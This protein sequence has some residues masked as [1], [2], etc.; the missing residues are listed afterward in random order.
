[1]VDALL[2]IISYAASPFLLEG[3][4]LAIQIT[5]VATVGGLALGLVLAAMRV[6]SIPPLRWFAWFYIWFVRGTPILLQLIF[7]FD[8]LPMFGVR[9]DN[10]TTAFI[11]FALNEAAYAAEYIRGGLLSVNRNQA[12]AASAHGMGPI[13]TLW[14]VI[15]PQAM[16]AIVPQLGNSVI[17]MVK[18]TS[19]ASVIFVNELSFRASQ[20]AAENF[21]Y[22]TVLTAAALVYLTITTVLSVVQDW[23]ERRFNVQLDRSRNFFGQF[24]LLSPKAK[25]AVDI[26][27]PVTEQPS[28]FGRS[29]PTTFN[30]L[31]SSIST[32]ANANVDTGTEPTRF[33]VGTNIHKYY[34][35]RHILRGIDFKIKRGEVVAIIGPSGSGKST[36]LR[37]INH[38]ESVDDGEVLVDGKH[39]GYTPSPNGP[40]PIKQLARARAEARIGMVFQNFNLFEHMTALQNVMA[41]PVFVHHE[42]EAAVRDRSIQL[43]ES[44]G[45]ANHIDHLPHRLS[46]GQQQR[47]AIARALAVSPKLMLFDEPTSALDPELVGEVL[48]VMRRLAESGMTMIVVT[49][50]IRFAHDV[51]DRVIFMDNGEIV[52][53]G[54]PAE[55]IDNPRNPRTRKFL[56]QVV[57]QE[58]EGEV[59]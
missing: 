47:V 24:R 6:S 21:K 11:G 55:V 14:R 9:M 26:T 57:Q 34:N 20:I 28:A 19:V 50:E 39:V 1:M 31:I 44:M 8:V 37:M 4:W 59:A 54:T 15:L 10:L 2:E 16:K 23:M 12:I 46:G 7:L 38:L 32:N 53:Q 3:A 43:L 13:S 25:P 58:V 22:L 56:R 30:A 40:V 33:V 18:T 36:L 48:A 51:A 29:T 27:Q 41:A 49:H 35:K 42:D 17:N 5:L 52:E 45:L